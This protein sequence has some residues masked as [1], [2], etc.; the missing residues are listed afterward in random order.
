MGK[1]KAKFCLLFFQWCEPLVSLS[2]HSSWKVRCC[3]TKCG[4]ITLFDVTL[5]CND[6]KSEEYVLFSIGGDSLNKK[7]QCWYRTVI[8]WC[9]SWQYTGIYE[10]G[11][12]YEQG[13]EVK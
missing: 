4:A 12:L 7:V 10:D 13:G 6:T 9:I 3:D 8:F 2:S 5:Q 1:T 11:H